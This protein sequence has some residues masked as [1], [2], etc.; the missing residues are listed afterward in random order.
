MLH[1][2]ENW[3]PSLRAL[4]RRLPAGGRFLCIDIG[5]SPVTALLARLLP[6]ALRHSFPA[7]QSFTLAALLAELRKAGFMLERVERGR[8]F[9]V[10][11]RKA[12]RR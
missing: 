4:L 1:H 10:I 8:E 2:V 12:A 9:A 3:R 5:Y 7:G 11:A 6:P